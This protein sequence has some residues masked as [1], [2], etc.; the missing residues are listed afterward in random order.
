[1]RAKDLYDLAVKIVKKAGLLEGFMGYPEPV[2]FVAHGI[3]L[4]MD[5]WPVIGKNSDHILQERMVVAMEPKFLFPGEGIVGIENTF[6]ITEKGMEK[7]NR[8]PEEI[9]VC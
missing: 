2:P 9:V 4:E 7:L 6:A 1:M 3:G 5:E 8:F